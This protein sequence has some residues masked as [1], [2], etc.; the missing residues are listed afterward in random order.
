MCDEFIK[1]GYKIVT[2]GTDN[3]LFLLDLTDTGLSGKEV[4]NGC[5]EEG[6]TLNKNC[7]PNETRSPFQ[8]S[9]VRI[10]TAAMTTKGWKE[11]HFVSLA[12]IIMDYLEI[13]KEN[14]QKEYRDIY[15]QKVLDLIKSI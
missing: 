13:M 2:G 8:T 7:V 15:T 10:G 6:I 11:D 14:K 5:E 12:N 9:G 1:M 3:H 4:Q